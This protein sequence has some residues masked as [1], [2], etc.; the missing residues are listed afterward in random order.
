VLTL[1]QIDAFERQLK[2][3]IVARNKRGGGGVTVIEA[4]DEA[5][6]WPRLLTHSPH[7]RRTS[8]LNKW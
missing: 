6:L 4:I 3:A 7:S 5:A 8:Q 2:A 1:A